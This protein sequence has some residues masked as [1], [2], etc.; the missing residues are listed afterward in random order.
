[1][2]SAPADEICIARTGRISSTTGGF[3]EQ[4]ANIKAMVN[5]ESRL[6]KLAATFDRELFIM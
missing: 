6:T 4:E 3:S 2:F 1:M 5:T